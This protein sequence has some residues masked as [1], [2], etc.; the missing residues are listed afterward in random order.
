MTDVPDWLLPSPIYL[1]LLLVVLTLIAFRTRRKNG[2][3]R[4]RWALL[5]AVA[6]SWIFATPVVANQLLFALEGRY[7]PDAG[8][9]IAPDSTVLIAVLASGDAFDSSRDDEYQLDAA[10]MHRS[11]AAVRLWKE[12]GGRVAFFGS[13]WQTEGPS[14]AARM[15]RLAHAMGVPF[16]NIEVYPGSFD[17]HQ[18]ILALAGLPIQDKTVF[19]VTSAAHMPRAMSV[20]RRYGLQPVPHPCDFR[21]RSDLGAAAWLPSGKALGVFR[22]VLHERIG[23]VYY[24]LRGWS[25]SS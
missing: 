12:R 24:R 21:A 9:T 13:A 20:A 22:Y 25:A 19:L 23:L 5:L 2:L 6:W 7:M 1:V 18:N 14:I 11:L 17:T 16:A 10:S 8:F 15:A 3:R 4:F